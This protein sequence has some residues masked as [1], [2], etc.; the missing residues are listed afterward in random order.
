MAERG[1][2]LGT[3]R[4]RPGEGFDALA[5]FRLAA[6][7]LLALIAGPVS[8]LQA[9]PSRVTCEAR[10]P[11][12][13]RD[14]GDCMGGEPGF[15]VVDVRH[16]TAEDAQ[17]IG[18]V[19]DAAVRAGWTYLGELTQKP[20]F[21]PADWDHLVADHAPPRGL[22]VAT[23]RA[24]QVVGYTAVHPEDGEM[25]LLFVH[26]GAGRGIGR[27]LLSAAHNALRAAGCQ[28]AYLYTHEQNERALAVYESAGYRRDGSVRESDFGGKSIRELRLVMQL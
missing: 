5:P 22:M 19:F 11:R 23:D 14:Q 13:L 1:A 6:H 12:R 24:G 3:K 15:A 4:C 20:M 18:A 7:T 28:Q 2:V 8:C 21:A 16:A 9:T 17:P 27:T 25:F 10:R 26:P